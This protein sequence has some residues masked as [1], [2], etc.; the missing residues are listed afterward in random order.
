MKKESLEKRAERLGI[1]ISQLHYRI[2]TLHLKTDKEIM[3]YC[4]E[5]TG[6]PTN[7]A[8]EQKKNKHEIKFD[9]SHLKTDYILRDIFLKLAEDE[10]KK[11]DL[12]FLY[13]MTAKVS[14][15]IAERKKQMALI[16]G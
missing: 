6:R 9:T 13:Q 4:S 5:L 14:L 1:S 8:I 7:K 11:Y 12:E 3:E 15:K 2:Y 10:P 16:G